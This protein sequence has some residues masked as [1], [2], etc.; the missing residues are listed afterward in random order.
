MWFEWQTI[1]DFDT[2]HL[3]LC[4]QLGYPETARNQATGKL[5]KKA[6]PVVAY[7][8]SIECE[9]KIIAWV[10]EEHSAGLTETNLR[11]PIPEI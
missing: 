1:E 9:E 11:P 5:D 4:D 10:E 7:T 2:W 8:T 3:A 6:Q